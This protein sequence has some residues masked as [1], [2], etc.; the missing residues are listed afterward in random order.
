MNVGINAPIQIEFS[1]PISPALIGQI[2]LLIG[3]TPVAVT[4]AVT[5]LNQVVTLTP[6]LPLAANT[7]Y[8]ISVTGVKDTT[9]NTMVGTTTS[10]FTTG[11]TVD[12][13]APTLV[14]ITPANNAASV[15]VN[16]TIT[17]VF[18]KAMNPVSFDLNNGY[19]TLATTN[20]SIAVP[21]AISFS[22]DFKTV[23]LTPTSAL[24]AATQYTVTVYGGPQLTDV[25]GNPLATGATSNFATQ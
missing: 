14:S 17:L 22:A 10:T 25:S 7:T 20:T 13:T 24:T 5:T 9:G 16:T 19:L 3:S 6:D 1:K 18:S 12:Y 21:F 4:P 15:S 23:T 8:T 11:P 2:S